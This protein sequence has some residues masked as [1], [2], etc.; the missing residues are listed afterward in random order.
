M[1]V[2]EGAAATR[3]SSNDIF[4]REPE[5]RGMIF[6]DDN[7]D[8]QCCRVLRRNADYVLR[9]QPERV[10]EPGREKFYLNRA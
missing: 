4:L 5:T 1:I 3:I 9:L 7:L 8:R 2:A 10:L 6:G